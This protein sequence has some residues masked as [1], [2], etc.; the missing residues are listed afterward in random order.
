MD[1]RLT[2]TVLRGRWGLLLLCGAVVIAAAGAWLTGRKPNPDVK[3]LSAKQTSGEPPSGKGEDKQTYQAYAG[4]ASCRQCHQ[5]EYRLWSSSHHGLAQ[6]LPDP[7]VDDAAFDP[8]RT[9]HQANQ[10]TAVRKTGAGYEILATGLNGTQELFRVEGVL[11]V[12]PLRQFLV[13]FPGGRRQALAESYDPRSNEWFNVF[14]SENRQPGEW[15]H[16]TGRGMNWNSMCAGCHNTRVQKNYNEKTDSFDTEMAERGVGCEACHGPMR[17]HTEWQREFAKS[18]KKDPT[19]GKLP[20]ARVVD[21][22]GFCHARRGDLTGDFKPGDA[23]SDDMELEIP[24][25]SEVFYADGQVHEEDYEYAAF[26]GSRMHARG[27]SC[28]DCHNPHSAKTILPGN[29]L[30]MRCHNGTYT[31]APIIDPVRHSHHRVFGYSAAGVLTNLDLTAYERGPVAETGGA[32]VNCH[33]PQTVYMQ[34]HWRH[35]HGFTIPDPLLTKEAGIPNACNRCHRD[36]D[37][38]W[39]QRYCDSWY[40]PKME[41][42]TRERARLLLAARKREPTAWRGLLGLLATN[43]LGYWRAVGAGLLQPWIGEPAVRDGLARG[44]N[45]TNALVRLQCARS[46]EPLASEPGVATELQGRLQDPVRGVRVAAAWALRRTLDLNTGPGKE[47]LRCLELNADQP[48]GQMQLGAFTLAHGE[49]DQAAAHYQKA[50]EWD[51]NSAVIRHDYAVALSTLNRPQ[52]AVEQ[53]QA[54]CKLEPTNAEFE[55]KLA[56]GWNELD[57]TTKAI[58]CL[59]KAVELDPHHAAAW[60]NLGLALSADGRTEEALDA[61]LRAETVDGSDPRSPYARATILARL[62]K[63]EEARRAAQRSLEINPGFEAARE[64]LKQL[65]GANERK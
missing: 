14:G 43:E 24:G 58:E 30:C 27:V 21:N 19:L 46:L 37:A 22:C 38:D 34:R 26:L 13:N 49:P 40:G 31:N 7:K 61:L 50:V 9:L 28:G 8:S 2:R 32:C 57:Q 41:R 64:L 60:Y 51:P 44:L 23:F 56:L 6:R 36:K 35:D 55:Y 12:S 59:R 42:P 3:T 39:A 48:V 65:A 52:E 63:L 15:G 1:R 20:A 62:G 53:L 16:W 25:A 29:W 11:G 10:T 45:D 33:M 4:S 47:L 17:A 5:E 18:G 54:A